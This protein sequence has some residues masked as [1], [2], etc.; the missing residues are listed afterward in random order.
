MKEMEKNRVCTVVCSVA[1]VMVTGIQATGKKG[2][3]MADIQRALAR[4][5]KNISHGLPDWGK[6]LPD[7]VRNVV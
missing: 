6:D 7:D 2:R 1:V 4:R 5:R 3:S